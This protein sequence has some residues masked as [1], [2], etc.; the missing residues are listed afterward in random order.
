MNVVALVPA[1]GQ[2]RR[3]G[4]PKLLL[5]RAGESVIANVVRAL[6]QGG[7]ETVLVVV[8]PPGE[9]GAALLA[10]EARDQGALVASCPV[11]TSDMRATIEFG[12]ATLI[13][14]GRAPS[15]GLL[16]TPGDLPNL[17]AA[18][19]RAVITRF[20]DQ[21]DRIVAPRHAGRRGHPL[22]LPW[23]IAEGIPRLPAGVGVNA[24]VRQHEQSI[25]AFD[26]DD[27]RSFIDLDTPDDYRAWVES[28][29]P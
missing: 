1:A 4:R 10:D 16:L 19:V 25:V 21:P 26:I 28:N 2:S 13:E 6:K 17:N 22:A 27:A 18:I 12:I 8:P 23:A 29:R 11:Q 3:M 7:V 24:L 14:Q 5:R 20:Q 15:D 9:P